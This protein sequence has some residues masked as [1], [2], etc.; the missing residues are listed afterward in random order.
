VTR[1][2][3][4]PLYAPPDAEPVPQLTLEIVAEDDELAEAVDRFIFLDPV[5]RARVGCINLHQD[6]LRV[7]DPPTWPLY[8]RTEELMT[9]RFA[10]VSVEI[11]RWAFN[12]GVRV[13]RGQ[14]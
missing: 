4:P 14:R 7:A 13:G 8:L 2:P 10:D 11:A 6:A 1:S 9:E 5:A 3:P 12:E